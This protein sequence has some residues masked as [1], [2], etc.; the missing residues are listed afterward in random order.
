MSTLRW[1]ALSINGSKLSSTTMPTTTTTTTTRADIAVSTLVTT[2]STI[3]TETATITAETVYPT[4]PYLAYQPAFAY[5]LPVQF[6]LTGVI[7]S[8]CSI[9][10]IHL[11][12]TTPYHWPLARLNY[13][14][15]LS[16]ISTLLLRLAITLSVILTSV[17]KTSRQWPY[18]LDYVAVDVPLANWTIVDNGLWY[19]LDATTSGLA[20]VMIIHSL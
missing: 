10:L 9:L 17:R 14:L 3:V 13:S 7:I 8:L 19:T 2:I 15:Q 12:F 16:G 4:D 20:H 11:I 5:S 18:M 1:L 6:V